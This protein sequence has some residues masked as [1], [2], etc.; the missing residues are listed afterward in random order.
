MAKKGKDFSGSLG[1]KN[2]SSLI[3]T[4]EPESPKPSS[5]KELVKPQK[6]N[7]GTTV[8]TFRIQNENLE[9]IKAIAFWERMKI[10]DVFNEALSD[11]IQKMPKTTFKK[12]LEEYKKRKQ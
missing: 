6:E 12:A 5:K 10:Q 4:G 2:L 9:A 8:T 7:S 1:S 3:P 11:Y